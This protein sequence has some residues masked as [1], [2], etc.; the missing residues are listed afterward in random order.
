MYSDQK[1]ILPKALTESFLIQESPLKDVSLI[2]GSL[3]PKSKMMS[4]FPRTPK[5]SKTQRTTTT[6]AKWSTLSVSGVR[7]GLPTLE[8]TI[9]Y[10]KVKSKC[11]RTARVAPDTSR[12]D[13]SNTCP[14]F[15]GLFD[16]QILSST[17]SKNFFKNSKYLLK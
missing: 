12:G 7:R 11:I 1:P 8:D 3:S 9:D 17:D 6:A 2:K 13:M 15:T 16:S 4:P 10:D 14:N 5:F